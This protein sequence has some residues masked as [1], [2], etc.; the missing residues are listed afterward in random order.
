[1]DLCYEVRVGIHWEEQ[2]LRVGWSIR[3]DEANWCK[4]GVQSKGKSQGWNNQV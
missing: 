4:I 1:M 2:D 3:W